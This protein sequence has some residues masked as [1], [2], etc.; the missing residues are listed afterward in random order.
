[1]RGLNHQA[2]RMIP[3]YAV[4]SIC[5]TSALSLAHTISRF[6]HSTARPLHSGAAK[7]N[8]STHG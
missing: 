3:S 4:Q 6:F 8:V 5:G 7:H 2:I 1:M